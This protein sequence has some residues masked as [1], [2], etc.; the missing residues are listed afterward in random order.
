MVCQPRCQ[1]RS[2][3]FP[4]STIEGSKPSYSQGKRGTN[5]IEYRVLPLEVA[6]QGVA[7]LGLRQGLAHQS[8]LAL[9]RGQGG[10]FDIRG[11]E[12]LSAENLG[13]AFSRPHA[14]APPHFHHPS[15][16]TRVSDL[17]IPQ[18]RLSPSTRF[19]A[20]SARPPVGGWRC[21][22]PVGGDEGFAISRPVVRGPP[23]GPPLGSG[24]QCGP[25]GGGFRLAAG[26][27]PRM[28]HPQ[29]TGQSAG[30]P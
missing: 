4:F 30:S 3:W 5:N 20:R 23:W 8:P 10:A 19:R 22:G 27:R 1:R 14:Y 13:E 28:D 2:S 16:L 21:R 18:A 15:P 7:L 11:V 17:G 12:G 29:R 25:K 6:V 26:L 24:L 9:S